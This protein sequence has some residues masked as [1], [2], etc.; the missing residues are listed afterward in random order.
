MKVIV[1]WIYLSIS[2]CFAV[3]SQYPDFKNLEG[4]LYSS[5]VGPAVCFRLTNDNSQ[6]G[7]SGKALSK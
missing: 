3:H 5:I 4:N 7:C 1:N 6:I 2:G